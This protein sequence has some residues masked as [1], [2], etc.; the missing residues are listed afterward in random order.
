MRRLMSTTIAALPL[1]GLVALALAGPGG[2]RS[3][4]LVKCS[5]TIPPVDSLGR[6]IDLTGTWTGSDRQLYS[7]RQVGGCLWWSASKTGSSVFFGSVSS[8]GVKG[9]WAD[10]RS[11]SRGTTGPLTFLITSGN[12]VLLRRSSTGPLKYLRK[13]P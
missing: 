3:T 13:N 8:S 12:T 7:L 4:E 2:A 9:Q 5:S 6:Q 11:R 1:I 10:V